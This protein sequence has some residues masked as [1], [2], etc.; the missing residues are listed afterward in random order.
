M[1][2]AAGRR[3]SVDRSELVSPEEREEITRELAEDPLV[4][5]RCLR[6]RSQEPAPKRQRGLDTMSDEQ[7]AQHWAQ[8]NAWCD[9]R[10]GA[11][12]EAEREF[13]KDVH[14]QVIAAERRLWRDEIAALRAELR[15]E[16]NAK[17]AV[18]DLPK[19]PLLKRVHDNAA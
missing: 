6:E 8:W 4:R 12:I 11:A 18:I 9:A 3:A 1:G 13:M 7:Q 2:R 5:W 19:L 17:N 14:A 16:D 10:I 15:K